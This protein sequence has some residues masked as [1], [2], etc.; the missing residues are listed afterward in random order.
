V[1]I[2]P[3]STNYFL[4][5]AQ[6][7]GSHQFS[8]AGLGNTV[9]VTGGDGAFVAIDQNEPQY[10]FTSYVFN[11]YRRSTNSGATWSSINWSGSDG[12]FINPYDY[13]N[14]NNKIYA[15][16][17]ANNYFRWD[18]PQSGVTAVSQPLANINGTVISAVTV[19]PYTSNQVYFGTDNSGGGCRIVKVADA[20]AAITETNISTGLPTAATVSCINVG[21]TD[22][23]LMA[24]FSN[25]GI[26]QIWVST[27][28]GT[29]WT[30]ID[31]DL[32]DMPV[33]WCMFSPGNNDGAIIATE[34]GVYLTHF[35]NGAS[36]AWIPSPTFPTVRTDMIKYRP[37]DGLV[38]A[39]TH[40]R[41]LW[42]QAYLT[43]VPTSTFLLRGRWA[44]NK[45]ELQ[46]EYS[47]VVAG[48]A[49]LDIEVSKD[50]VNF[51]KLGSLSSGSSK[52]Y[53]YTHTPNQNNVYYRIRSREA[54]GMVKYSNTI[55]L[56]KN[57]TDNLLTISS[58]FPNPVQHELNVALTAEKGRLVYNITAMNGQQV[59]RKEEDL[60]FNGN[61]I[62]KL[63]ISGIPP[64]NYILTLLNG[65][66]KTSKKFIKSK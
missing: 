59:W 65:T 47:P 43:I 46:W 18:N 22:S 13:D 56:F 58:L 6:D 36:T 66:E 51:V 24:C 19:S 63:N 60:Q 27:N 4:A 57:G 49:T 53:N 23:Y 37:S 29:S 62:R 5:G 31:G 45:T 35:I 11:Q 12:Q 55:K 9:E 41:G 20:H 30:N 64:G 14:V 2:H 8:M 33:R 32:P 39:A 38:A 50:A 15:A 44:G 21:T 3:S 40:G 1:A 16:W 17:S 34:A 52:F 54:N 28:G 61:Y 25:Y 10:Q 48:T 42:T 7:N 26:Q